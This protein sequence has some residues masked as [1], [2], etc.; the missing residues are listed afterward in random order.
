[1]RLRDA[2]LSA[3]ATLGN[4]RIGR[5]DAQRLL[6]GGPAGAQHA[7]LAALL[8]AAAAPGRPA[9]LTDEPAMV[10]AFVRAQREP[11]PSPGRA[12][13]WR[14][15]RFAVVKVATGVLLF[16]T[17]GTAF[18][19]E[20]GTLPAGLQRQAHG[21]FSSLGV[22]TPD[23][24]RTAGSRPG[25]PKSTRGVPPA[26]S[27]PS[28]GPGDPATEKLCRAW[29]ASQRDPHGRAMAPKQLRELIIRAGDAA[30]IPA[31]CAERIDDGPPD[32]TGVAPASSPPTGR[33]GHGDDDGGVPD[34]DPPGK[35]GDPP[36]PGKDPP[37]EGKGPPG[38]GGDPPGD[39]KGPPGDSGHGPRGG[40]AGE[41]SGRG[42]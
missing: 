7:E 37:G 12:R 6:D 32:S 33:Q 18:A 29:A 8:A 31:L 4:R 25:A 3:M 34:G 40:T 39:G 5:A 41:D 36:G 14:P 38:D 28:P 22:P 19:A 26:S 24:D 16:A 35:G 10:A 13:A 27:R 23:A 2:F 20:T 17:V 1:M 15:G 21:L 42:G 30:E 9:E 11:S